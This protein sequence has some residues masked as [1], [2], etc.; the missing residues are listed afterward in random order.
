M[1][2]Y[3]TLADLLDRFPEAELIQL[4]DDAGAGS[5]DQARIDR[6]L[7]A[8]SATIDG[9][10]AAQYQLPLARVPDNVI[11]ICC[12]IARFKLWRTTPPENVE[13]ANAAALKTLEQISKG[14]IK[15]DAGMREQ[16]ARDGAI[17]VEGGERI[18]GRDSMKGY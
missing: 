9:Y 2:A 7:T 14:V 1:P 16:P 5:V 12:D 8:A 4:T 11:D 3:A 15:I 18:F 6:A 10:L 13:K 17:V